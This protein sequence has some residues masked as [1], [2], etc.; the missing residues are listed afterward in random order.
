MDRV[1]MQRAP[2]GMHLDDVVVRAHDRSGKPAILEIQVKR[3]IT[4]A[5]KDAVF[6]EV[7]EQ[8]AKTAAK[9]DFWTSNHQLGIATSATSRK[10]NGPYQNVLTWVRQ[11]GDAKTFMEQVERTGTS[12][13]EA[14]SFVS[15]F[16]SHL[17]EA[18]A[19]HDDETVWKVL[20]RLRILTTSPHRS[21]PLRSLHRNDV[22]EHS[23]RTKLAEQPICGRC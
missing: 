11:I 20:R 18:G 21:R 3:T 23:N 19:P 4:F 6:K 9:P 17:K 14:R 15:T 16:R 12:N 2:Q 5:P 1:E 10:I 8:I 22:P 13:D 7:V